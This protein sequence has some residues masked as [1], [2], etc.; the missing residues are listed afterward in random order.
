MM[1]PDFQF[2]D[3]YKFLVSAGLV[4]IALALVIPWFLL[5]SSL[6]LVISADEFAKLIPVAQQLLRLRQ[7]MVLGLLANLPWISSGVFLTGLACI[8]LGMRLWYQRHQEQELLKRLEEKQKKSTLEAASPDQIQRALKQAR[9]ELALPDE[10]TTPQDFPDNRLSISRYWH[11]KAQVIQKLRDC[12]KSTH[13][14]IEDF[15][16]GGY[17]FVFLRPRRQDPASLV[18][19][20]YIDRPQTRDSLI[21]IVSPVLLAVQVYTH[22]YKGAA[23]IN[24]TVFMVLANNDAVQ[25][26][27]RQAFSQHLGSSGRQM[28]VHFCNESSLGELD[29]E[30][31]TRTLFG[32]SL[33]KPKL[34]VLDQA[35]PSFWKKLQYFFQTAWLGMLIV[36]IIL[37]FM[38][39]N[40]LPPLI[41]APH[42]TLLATATI[43]P[44]ITKTLPVAANTPIATSSPYI[45]STEEPPQ[46]QIV[47]ALRELSL[48]QWIAILLGGALLFYLFY[49]V[50]RFKNAPRGYLIFTLNNETFSTH[51]LPIFSSVIYSPTLASIGI[52]KIKFRDIYQDDEKGLLLTVFDPTHKRKILCSVVLRE[53][54]PSPILTDDFVEIE[55]RPVDFD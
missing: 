16:I 40:T 3:P 53:R 39:G 44:S 7:S 24:G 50:Y 23:E 8:A 47:D 6:D 13:Q 35:A 31:I 48:W 12:L 2:S 29:Q 41:I 14:V 52:G 22:D 55:Y 43:S 51:L 33:D 45:P 5:Q 25:K 42:P 26:D 34:P 54:T 28:Q 38:M 49:L 27:V 36:G 18:A 11:V 20:R 4:L 19:V 30:Q 32:H 10:G 9:L 15:P 1:K 21:N 37:G 46:I 17:S